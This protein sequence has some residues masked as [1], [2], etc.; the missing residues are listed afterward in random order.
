MQALATW[1]QLVP[2]DSMASFAA[3]KQLAVQS[4]IVSEEH[5]PEISNAFCGMIVGNHSQSSL[6]A[7]TTKMQARYG[8]F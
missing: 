5:P 1:K 7:W 3:S 6:S 4:R 8:Q 2:V